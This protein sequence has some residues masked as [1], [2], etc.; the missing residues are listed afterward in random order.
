LVLAAS[1]LFDATS[2]VPDFDPTTVPVGYRLPFVLARRETAGIAVL[3]PYER[4]GT[5]TAVV[6]TILEH[7]MR[8]QDC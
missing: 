7:D 2:T 5:Y 1:D 6:T 4:R 8:T 3:S